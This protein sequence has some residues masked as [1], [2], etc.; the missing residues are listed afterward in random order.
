M[1]RPA[2]FPARSMDYDA[3]SDS[4]DEFDPEEDFWEDD[5]EE[6]NGN[7]VLD[8]DEDDQDA[9]VASSSGDGPVVEFAGLTTWS[10][11]WCSSW[12][13]SCF[14]AL[15]CENAPPQWLQCAGALT[16]W[17]KSETCQ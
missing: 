4:V 6:L 9:P 14:S 5:A 11:P 12:D 3:D 16:F 15:D 10:V 2:A 7:E 8:A 13:T 1:L 17:P